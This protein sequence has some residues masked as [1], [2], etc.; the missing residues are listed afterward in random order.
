VAFVAGV[1]LR[2]WTFSLP[3]IMFAEVSPPHAAM[4]VG[5]FLEG[6]SET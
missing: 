5:S 2:I 6:V 3:P 4:I 1:V